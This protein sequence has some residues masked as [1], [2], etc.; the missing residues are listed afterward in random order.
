VFARD[1]ILFGRELRT[2]LRIRLLDFGFVRVGLIHDFPALLDGREIITAR[3]FLNSR[4]GGRT[5]KGT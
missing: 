4:S 3:R 1:V 2:P 5:L